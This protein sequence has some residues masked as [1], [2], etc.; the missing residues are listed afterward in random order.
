MRALWVPKVKVIHWP[1]STS[2]RFNIFK[3]LFVSNRWFYYIL[4]TQVSD[5][6]PMVL[7]FFFN[8]FTVL[9]IIFDLGFL[10]NGSSLS[11]LHHF[12][13]EHLFLSKLCHDVIMSLSQCHHVATKYCA[14]T[15]ETIWVFDTA[16]FNMVERCRKMMQSC[17]WKSCLEKGLI[18][19]NGAWR[20]WI[21]L[22]KI[23]SVNETMCNIRL[24]FCFWH[25][26]F[27]CL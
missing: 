1:W 21:K 26:T 27:L 10:K 22:W 4:S 7:C 24:C 25:V 18:S 8:T 20:W 16:C 3:L 23:Y 2:L 15:E 17:K 13:A 6:G 14:E 19:Q 11:I 9:F 5:T 12:S